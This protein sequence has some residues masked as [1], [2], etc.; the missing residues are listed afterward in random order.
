MEVFTHLNEANF[1]T[2]TVKL[3]GEL[4]SLSRGN[5][6][7]ESGNNAW[8]SKGVKTSATRHCASR[9]IHDVPTENKLLE[10]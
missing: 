2:V 4:W 7:A 6:A 3:K 9:N 8:Q 10:V 5:T 1:A